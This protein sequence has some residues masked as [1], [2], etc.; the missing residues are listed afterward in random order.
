M[1]AGR[2]DGTG[3]EVK[4]ISY[5]PATVTTLFFLAIGHLLGWLQ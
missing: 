2:Q 5:L 1:R 3:E 4:L